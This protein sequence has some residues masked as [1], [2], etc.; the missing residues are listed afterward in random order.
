MSKL[1][2]SLIKFMG[3]VHISSHQPDIWNGISSDQ[4]TESIFMCCGH[5]PARIMGFTLL[6][7][8]LKRWALRLFIYA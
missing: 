5:I 2:D 3:N 6:P 8:T 4:F 1:L 7:S